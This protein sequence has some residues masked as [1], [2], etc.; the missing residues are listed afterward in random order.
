MA[1]AAAAKPGASPAAVSRAASEVMCR[2]GSYTRVRK[3]LARVVT[4]AARAPSAP[5]SPG[6]APGGHV[7]NP[8]VAIAD[9]GTVTVV[10]DRAEMGQGAVTGLAMLVAEELEVDLSQ[11]RTA[12][13]PVDPAYANPMF[14]EQSTGGSTTIRSSYEPLRRAGA[15]AREMLVAAAAARWQVPVAECKAE[16]GAVRHTPSNKVLGYGALA[17]AAAKVRPPANPALKA[18]SAFRLIGKPTQRLELPGHVRGETKFG[19]DAQMPGLTYAA[20]QR[21]PAPGAT[22]SGADTRAA[23]RVPGVLRVVEVA[24]GLAVVATTPSAAFAGRA[25]LGAKYVGRGPDSASIA[26]TLDAAL[27]KPGRVKV[28]NGDV[29]AVLRRATN[30][31]DATYAT[32]FQAHAPME[33]MNCTVRIE[34]KRADVWVGSQSLA[35]VRN[36]VAQETGIPARAVTVHGTFLGGSFGRRMES[37]FVAEAAQV[38]KAAAS[39]GIGP[40]QLL[41]SRDDDM[42]HGSFRPPNRVRLRGSVDVRGRIDALSLKGAGPGMSLDGI[43]MLYDVPNTREELV[44]VEVPI[45]LSAWRAVG[46]SNNGFVVEGFIDELAHAAGA[47]PLAFRLAHLSAQPRLAGVLRRVAQEANWDVPLP[48]G[49]GRG[50]AAYRSFGS[51]VAVIA[52]VTARPAGVPRVD[53]IVVA[54]DC[55]IVVNPDAVAAQMEGAAIFALGATLLSEITFRNGAVV[56]SSF[57]DYPIVRYNEAPLVEVHLVQSTEAPGGAGEPGVPPLAP[58]VVNA[59]FAATGQR[60]RA[61]PVRM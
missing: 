42:R 11:V 45:A 32:P 33:P 36:V 20:L 48:A 30:V 35:D 25:A 2:C 15:S 49:R 26:A 10:I 31:V 4:P 57:A 59:I 58:A 7:F 28:A 44:R 60:V 5:P 54:A 53:R 23:E 46:A 9:D 40:V 55:G 17:A 29:E 16:L 37:D 21:A 18:P 6:T 22:L 8:W 12:F 47:D 34:G 50:I 24:S 52:E 39:G 41:W 19:I 13:A 61:L 38:A 51:Y 43:N 56:E 14:G 3:A 1:A 27:D